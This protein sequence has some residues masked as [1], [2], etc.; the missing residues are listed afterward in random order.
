MR[1]VAQIAAKLRLWR[2]WPD[3]LFGRLVVILA[4]GMFAGQLLTRSIW[5][6]THDN[7]TLEIP[8]RLFGSRLADTVRLI[9]R[10]P[11]AAT[12]E[13]IVGT[14]VLRNRVVDG[15]TVGLDAELILPRGD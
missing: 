8:A 14:L 7:H 4:A 13:A 12:R 2:L 6:E 15:R 11:N 3:T 9:E 1:R 5:F 10:A